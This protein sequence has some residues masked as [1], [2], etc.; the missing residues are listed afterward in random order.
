M[1][2]EACLLVFLCLLWPF[3]VT[4]ALPNSANASENNR[5]FF[6]EGS[7]RQGRDAPYF[8]TSPSPSRTTIR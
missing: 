6:L 4:I 8:L 1:R 5:L 7:A 3:P 2:F